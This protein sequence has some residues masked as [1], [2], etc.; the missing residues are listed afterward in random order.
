ME[1]HK[2]LPIATIADQRK[3]LHINILIAIS[4][5]LI[6]LLLILWCGLV[7]RIR[8]AVLEREVDLQKVYQLMHQHEINAIN[9]Y[10]KGRK[11]NAV[12]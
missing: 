5:A 8:L 2:A 1:K 4:P 9:T 3:S 10:W 12:G 6:I 7:L 11:R